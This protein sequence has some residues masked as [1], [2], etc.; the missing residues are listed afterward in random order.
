V[1]V[2]ELVI[3]LRKSGVR[4][5]LAGEQLRLQGPSGALTPDLKQCV[6]QYRAEL[7]QLLRPGTA[8]GRTEGPTLSHNQQRL[9]FEQH[10]DPAAIHYNVPVVMRLGARVRVEAVAQ[11]LRAVVDSHAG[12][13]MRFPVRDD[14]PSV[15]M[16]AGREAFA[17]SIVDLPDPPADGGERAREA[18]TLACIRRPFDLT[19]GPLFRATLLRRPF[20]DAILAISFHHIVADGWSMG[21][22]MK[23]FQEAYEACVE[24]RPV[25][26]RDRPTHGYA[27][28]VAWQRESERGRTFDPAIARAK[29]LLSGLPDLRLPYDTLPL[30]Q[31]THRGGVCTARLSHV[32]VEGLATVATACRTTLFG[33][34]VAAFAV[35]LSA[36][37]RQERFALGSDVAGRD[38]SDWEPI[39][40]DFVNQ[41]VLAI[42]LTGNPPLDAIVRRTSLAFQEAYAARAVPFDVLVKALRRSPTDRAPLFRAKVVMQPPMDATLRGPDF[43]ILGVH[44][45][46][47]K[48]ELL[49][50][51]CVSDDAAIA[52]EYSRDVFAES[53]ASRILAR[54]MRLLGRMRGDMLSRPLAEIVAQLSSGDAPASPADTRERGRGMEPSFAALANM[55]PD[56]RCWFERIVCRQPDAIAIEVDDAQ[57]S[58][59]GL[60]ARAGRIAARLRGLGVGSETAV[61]VWCDRDLAL[62]ESLLAVVRAGGAYVPIDAAA[63]PERVRSLLAD[64]GVAVLV[65]DATRAARLGQVAAHVVDPRDV[66]RTGGAGA[67]DGPGAAPSAAI[68]PEQAAYVIYTSGST[69]RPK[70]VVVTH[71]NVAR[72]IA[73]THESFGVGASDVWTMFHSAA[74]DFSV[75][76]MWGCWLTGGRLVLVPFAVGRS[77]DAFQVLLLR[78][79]VTVLNQTPSAFDLWQAYLDDG[80]A[81]PGLRLV[82]FGGEALDPRRLR[83]WVERNGAERPTLVNMYGITETTVHVTARTLAAT[84]T[85][86]ACSPIGRALPDLRVAVLDAAG[87]PVSPGVE[88]ELYVGGA[89]VA[90]GYLH[91]PS[92]TAQRFVPAAFG[93]EVGAR[94]YRS[95]DR[96]YWSE[97]GLEYRG[98]SDDQVKIRGHR[99]EPR[100]I[101]AVLLRQAGVL[102]AAVAPSHASDGSKRLDAF[103]VGG[104]GGDVAALRTRLY[105]LLPDYMVPAIITAIDRM[106][107]TPNGKLDREALRRRLDDGVDR[108]DVL[109]TSDAVHDALQHACEQHG[110]RVAVSCDGAALR[111]SQLQLLSDGVAALLAHYDPGVVAVV[112]APLSHDAIV[113]TCA[114]LQLGAVVLRIDPA[115]PDAQRRALVRSAGAAVVLTE[116]PWRDE[117][118]TYDVLDLRAA[119]DGARESRPVSVRRR[120]D[121]DH[122]ACMTYEIDASGSA[123]FTLVSHRSV[124][125]RWRESRGGTEDG[126]SRLPLD[127]LLP[128]LRGESIVIRTP[129]AQRASTTASDIDRRR[130]EL[131]AQILGEWQRILDRAEVGADVNFLEAGGD[132]FSILQL[133]LRLRRMLAVDVPMIDMFKHA[134]VRRLA[135]HVA[136]LT[137]QAT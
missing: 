110:A 78:A 48:F 126:R 10:V 8:P 117:A 87:D 125:R 81:P 132:S 45:G 44:N 134:S 98:R 119:I 65:T 60:W 112:D 73:T 57:V 5:S 23:D 50:N 75:W 136:V 6:A 83:R 96:V 31:P 127:D 34:C 90:R 1:T 88:G 105:D 62:L 76:E 121:R 82:I 42:D 111:F 35:V 22:L 115:C 3:A 54:V 85:Q 29:A 9:W 94:C 130:G 86:A 72:L 84:D 118:S 122:P 24:G 107:L 77:P 124:L 68:A 27:D 15:E 104:A 114:M 102:Q 92:L 19:T 69:G 21:I 13:R 128:L 53:T 30:E 100:E 61:A 133:N 4:V 32:E 28:F 20:S 43:E 55:A 123:A 74:F 2:T 129:R 37:A 80:A 18:A 67:I 131:E 79:Q 49:L 12:L 47:S 71:A 106:P 91:Q 89:G 51:V 25:R 109:E 56:L 113:A 36:E 40:G 33:L 17:L 41:I 16:M 103:I 97:N 95:G 63:P 58:Y 70:G 14:R 93:D 137:Q 120:V 99:I 101:E 11:A 46:T 59:A 7:L 135:E 108:R 64:S 52:I 39:V 38:D 116:R 66:T 26:Q